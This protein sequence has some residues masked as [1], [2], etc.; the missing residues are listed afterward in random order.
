MPYVTEAGIERI[1]GDVSHPRNQKTLRRYLAERRA[2][3]VK[4]STIQNDANHLRHIAV[5]LGQKPFEEATREDVRDFVIAQTATRK[6]RHG[7]TKTAALSRTT[8]NIRIVV[9][10]AFFRWLKGTD[11]F[12]PEVKWLKPVKSSGED[13]MIAPYVIEGKELQAIIQAHDHPQDRAMLAT[14]YE[15]GLRASEFV[16][17]RIRDVT[18]DEYGA[19]IILPKGGVALKTGI[20]RVRL[21]DCAPYLQAWADIHPKKKQPNAPLWISRA[22]RNAGERLTSNA[23]WK[24]VSNAGKRGGL[25]K[26]IWPH[27]FRHSRA[28]ECA[29]IG[30]TESWMRAYFGWS[31][32]SDMPSHYVH[33]AGKDVEDEI[34]RRAGKLKGPKEV[35]RAIPPRECARCRKESPATADF[36]TNSACGRPLTVEAA[37]KAEAQRVERINETLAQMVA[38]QVHAAM[39]TVREGPSSS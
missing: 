39:A 38:A 17:L 9:V 28:T 13:D 31:R 20:R 16:S 1:L 15:S 5:F 32:S 12:P 26:E 4:L 18:F 24:F 10:K 23:L 25:D 14:L 21:V 35:Q 6:L 36:C 33:L 3:G 37:E 30:L 22:D 34:L 7:G 29:R 2:L 19:I 8:K 27:L 11:E